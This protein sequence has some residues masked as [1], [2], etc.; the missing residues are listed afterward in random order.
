MTDNEIIKALKCLC[1]DEIPCKDCAYKSDTFACRRMNAIDAL[2]L[3]KRQQAEIERLQ[4][5]N[6]EVAYKHYN[7]GIKEFAER[8]KEKIAKSVYNYWNTTAN[9]Y[10]LAEDVPDEID[11]LVKEM[12]EG[13]P[14]TEDA[15]CS[16]CEYCYFDGEYNECAVNG[17]KPIIRNWRGK[18]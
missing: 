10:Y 18:I 17:I 2:D 12:T 8:L 4:K 16:T 1:G 11:N 14:C 13:K 15:D 9:G 7:D 6:T 3:I 5:Y